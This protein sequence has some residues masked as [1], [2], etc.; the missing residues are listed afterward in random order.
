MSEAVDRFLALV[1]ATQD[2]DAALT[3]LQ[4]GLLVA[5]ELGIAS[6]S[7]S[8]ARMLGIAH[9][10]VLRDLSALTERDDKL[11]IVKRDPRTMRVHY[12]L[13]AL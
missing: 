12:S 3:S 10:L 8:F 6:D 1:A 13:A 4:A 5:A 2:G 9:A 11:R 7:R